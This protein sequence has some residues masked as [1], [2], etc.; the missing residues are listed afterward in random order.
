MR[1]R[2]ILTFALAAF[3]VAAVILIARQKEAPPA[4][5]NAAASAMPLAETMPAEVP[6]AEFE[7][8]AVSAAP[9]K[10]AEPPRAARVGEKAPVHKIVAMYFHGDVRCVTCRKV[11]AYAKEAI[12]SGFGSQI[13]SGLVEFR[14]INVE[15][16]GN[17]HFVDD[18]QLVTRS[19]VVT[20]ELDGVVQRFVKLDNV[21]GLVGNR[22][23]YHSYVQDAVRGYLETL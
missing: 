4:A 1:A 3:V 20:D 13:E 7:T 8:A 16:P 22:D 9:E 23:A 10:A 14:A 6:S 19:V 12:E 15:E 18:F 2:S 5:S 11:E 21:W 17:R